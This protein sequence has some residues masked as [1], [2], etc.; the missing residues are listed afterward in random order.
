MIKAD[1]AFGFFEDGFDRP[2]HA[3]DAYELDHGSFSRGIAEVEL[4]DRRI[5]QIAADDQPDFWTRQVCSRFDQAQESKVADDRSFAAF[6]DGGC[7]SSLLSEC[8]QPAPSPES[9]DHSDGA[10]A[11][12]SGDDHDLSTQGHALRVETLQIRSVALDFG[13]I[14]LVQCRYSIPKSRRIPVQFIRSHPLKGQTLPRFSAF[15]AI[16][17]QFLAWFGKPDLPVHHT[18]ALFAHALRQTTHPA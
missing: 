5:L 10:D 1:F 7:G 3:A 16:P 13:E 18:P 11:A 6:F 9:G 14:P 15:S 2:S 4:D 17:G 12:G 8:W